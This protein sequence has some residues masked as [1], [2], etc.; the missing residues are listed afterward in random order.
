MIHWNKVVKQLQCD[1]VVQPE[2]AQWQAAPNDEP[3]ALFSDLVFVAA[4]PAALQYFSCVHNEIINTALYDFSPRLQLNGQNS[5]EQARKLFAA[6]HEQ[7]QVQNWLHL[8]RDGVEL[9]T[10]LFLFP[11]DYDGKAMTMVRFEPMNRRSRPRPEKRN[12][13]EAVP[14]SVL[15]GILEESAEAVLLSDEQQTILVVNKALCRLTGYSS[16]QLVG[17]QVD[18][19]DVVGD[20]HIKECQLAL[21]E[22]DFW[23]GEVL[24]RRADG[25]QFPAWQNSRRITAEDG[26]TYLVTVFS[27]ISDRKQLEAR[28]TTQAMYDSLTGLPNRRHLKKLLAAALVESQQRTDAPLGALMFMDLNGFKHINDCFGHSM[29]DMILQLVAARLEAGCI[30]KADIARMGGDEFTLIITDCHNKDEVLQFAHKII[31]LF[32]TPFELQGQKFYLGASIGIGLFQHEPISAS[33]LLS[34]ADTA[35]YSAKKSAEHIMFYDS[36]MSE[37]AEHRLKLLGELRHAQSLGQFSLYYQP[38]VKL[39]DGAVTGAE[40]LL[41]WQ[42]TP[43][44]MLEAGD[45]VAL[46]EETGLIVSVGNWVLEQACKQ[47]AAWRQQH[48]PDFVISVNVSPMQLEHLDFPMQVEQILASTQFPPH[49]LMLEI[50]ESALLMH[51]QQARMTLA[52]LRTMGIQVAIDDFGTGFSS[53]SRLGHMP[54]DSLKIDGEFARELQHQ[55]GQ[56]LCQA[57]IQLSQALGLHFVAEGIETMQQKEQLLAMGDGLAQGFLFGYPLHAQQFA[58]THFHPHITQRLN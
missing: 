48:S 30:E 8:N 28:L 21:H 17:E 25:S 2:L 9:P 31:E 56:A 15:A 14:R 12:E 41:R 37:Q 33:L 42:K 40:A 18:T 32:D 22:R 4:N 13:F 36:S 16:A 51:P 24:R 43:N 5:I 47:A 11:V 49:A 55:R 54:I 50:T 1:A 3:L 35:M 6:A 27:D 39:S 26:R 38:I 53:L 34:Q 45:F 52:K 10:K 44:E 29:G 46:L 58:L 19:L 20:I 57:I 23:Q 7:P